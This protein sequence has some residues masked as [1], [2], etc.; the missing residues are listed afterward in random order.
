M[1]QP[2]LSPNMSATDAAFLYLERKEVPLHIASVCVF[3][4]PIPFQQFVAN[5]NSKLHLV[6]RYLQIP[7]MPSWDLEFPTWEDD[8]KFD[9]R[10]HVFPVTLPAPGG[11]AELQVLAS[12][13]LSQLLD[14]NKPLWDVH[15]VDGLK[16]GCGAIILRVH[17]ALA[18]GMSGAGLMRLLLDPSPEVP[19]AYPKPQYRKV[20]KAPAPQSTAETLS[21]ALNG[22][23]G[24]LLQFEAGMLGLAENVIGSKKHDSGEPAQSHVKGLVGL[25]PEFTAS[26]ERL[27]FNKPCTGKRKFCWAEFKMA[28]VQ[29]IRD[30]AGGTVNDVILAVVTRALSHYVKLHG[31][32]VVGRFVRV[33]CPV[34]L[35]APDEK[36]GTGNQISFLPVALPLDAHGP[37]RTLQEVTTRTETLKR[38][39]ALSFVGIA[40]K[41]FSAAPPPLQALFWRNIPEVILPVPLLNMICTNVVGSPTPLY[42]VGRRMLAAYP[43]VPTGWDLGVGC[44]AHS[45][46]GKLFFGL[47]AD[48]HAAPDVDRLRDFLSLS[49]E[50]LRRSAA[51]KRARR[52]QKP[53]PAARAPQE[54]ADKPVPTAAPE[55]S[56]VETPLAGARAAAVGHSKEAA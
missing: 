15:V 17:H 37:V 14:R 25:L 36:N 9:I 6:P 26:I 2:V 31:E 42:A 7:R 43:Q 12:C 39:G 4:G 55:S 56:S 49:F 13:I 29:A 52:V 3:D 45:Y 50:E 41:W 24:R 48:T 47:I 40:A 35:R 16:D 54:T 53:A 34:N 18:D 30:A 1:K 32:S 27:P 22:A 19:Q 46:D 11:E 38:S 51:K 23:L 44:A 21:T 5:I 20:R 33:V 10:R 28:D 8:P